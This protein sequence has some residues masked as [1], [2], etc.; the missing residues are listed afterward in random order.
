MNNVVFH[1][2]ACFAIEFALPATISSFKK[3]LS[4]KDGRL[5]RILC[6]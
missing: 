6:N 5:L 4:V 2:L 1:L 3:L